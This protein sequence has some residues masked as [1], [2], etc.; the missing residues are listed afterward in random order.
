MPMPVAVCM[1]LSSLPECNLLPEL[2]VLACDFLCL[3]LRL[4]LLLL[5]HGGVAA[6]QCTRHLVLRLRERR[7][8]RV[9]LRLDKL[10]L[11]RDLLCDGLVVCGD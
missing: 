5:P 3:R 11:L 8:V 7:G 2:L 1:S 10:L 9:E 4:L 6:S